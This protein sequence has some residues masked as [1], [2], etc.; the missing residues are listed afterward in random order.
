M[1]KLLLLTLLAAGCSAGPP[2][3]VAGKYAGY[4]GAQMSDTKL[5]CTGELKQKDDVVTG[6][7]HLMM[8]KDGKQMDLDCSADGNLSGNK[9]TLRLHGK[10]AHLEITI[11]GQ[12]LTDGQARIVGDSSLEGQDGSQPV[13]LRRE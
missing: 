12:Y 13:L 4:F 8:Q 3:Q 7:F 10:Q 6:S 5:G 2:A 1:K 9:L 11:K